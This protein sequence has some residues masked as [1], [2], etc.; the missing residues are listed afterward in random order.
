ML[1]SL[2]QRAGRVPGT[3]FASWTGARRRA[4]ILGASVR[5]GM[6]HPRAGTDN[7][8]GVV[9]ARD[10][11]ISGCTI[12]LSTGQR[13]I[14]VESR[15]GASG[16]QVSSLNLSGIHTFGGGKHGIFVL[17][18]GQEGGVEQISLHEIRIDDAEVGLWVGSRFRQPVRS[19]RD[20]SGISIYGSSKGALVLLRVKIVCSLISRFRR[21]TG[22]VSKRVSSPASQFEVCS[23]RASG[24]LRAMN[25]IPAKPSHWSAV[26][27]KMEAHCWST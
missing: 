27:D 18:Q 3:C 6:W 12:D 24:L 21:I 11:S 19:Q 2:V 9:S 5:G 13:G 15:F 1:R 14:V 26:P 17:A 16:Q 4:R 7:A 22:Q 25:P 20:G 10:C 8:I 23:S